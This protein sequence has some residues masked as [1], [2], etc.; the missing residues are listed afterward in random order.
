[1]NAHLKLAS[2]YALR[3]QEVASR[4]RRVP[5]RI[6]CTLTYEGGGEVRSVTSQII[7]QADRKEKQAI[8]LE[9]IRVHVPANE[10]NHYISE[11]CNNLN[12]FF[13]GE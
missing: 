13:G 3:M 4:T 7:S 8:V 2:G 1:M 11:F 12:R 9:A 6:H 5:K 10:K